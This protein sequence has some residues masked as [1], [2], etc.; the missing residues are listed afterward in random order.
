MQGIGELRVNF[1]VKLDHFGF[2]RNVVEPQAKI[3]EVHDDEPEEE[4]PARGHRL[5]GQETNP[6]L[7]LRSARLV[8]AAT[9]GTPVL[10]H[11]PGHDPDVDQEHQEQ[12]PFDDGKDPKLPQPV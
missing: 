8:A 2:R 6:A 7:L 4:D 5:A 10:D 11:Q 9:S 1:S 12:P 3:R